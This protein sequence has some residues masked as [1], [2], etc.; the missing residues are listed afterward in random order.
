M[1]SQIQKTFAFGGL[2]APLSKEIIETALKNVQP[3]EIRK[4]WVE[5]GEH[6]YP[7]KQAIA[8]A[9]GFPEE[10]FVTSAAIRALTILGFEVKS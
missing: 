9:T 5:V 8:A 3:R 10:Q 1:E 6:R 7:I 2:R 4:Y